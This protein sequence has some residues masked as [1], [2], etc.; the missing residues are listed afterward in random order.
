MTRI[1]FHQ[2]RLSFQLPLQGSLICTA[3]AQYRQFCLH[4]SSIA[5]QSNEIVTKKL[6]TFCKHKSIIGSSIIVTS[7]VSIFQLIRRVDNVKG[8]ELTSI[9][10]ELTFTRRY[11][12]KVVCLYHVKEVHSKEAS[13]NIRGSTRRTRS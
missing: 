7:G 12:V 6:F 1:R 2:S 3:H 10:S 11:H 4:A 13:T 5:F 9:L 8:E